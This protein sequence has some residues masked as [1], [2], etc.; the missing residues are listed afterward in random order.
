M[1]H[2]HMVVLTEVVLLLQI[3]TNGRMLRHNQGL[4]G[5]GISVVVMRVNIRAVAVAVRSSPFGGD[6]NGGLGGS[7]MVVIK[8]QV[9]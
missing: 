9:K 8:F 3:R 2:P 1:V 5:I 6:G 4:P 7:G